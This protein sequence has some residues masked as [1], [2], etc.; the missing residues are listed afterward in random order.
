MVSIYIQMHKQ[1]GDVI[2]VYEIVCELRG[3]VP[4]AVTTKMS[5][6]PGISGHL[7]SIDE[8]GNG[9]G[10]GNSG[11]NGNGNGGGGGRGNGRNL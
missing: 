1:N 7:D 10:N 3:A 5:R 4:G 6:W 11:N 2:C 9:R 8:S